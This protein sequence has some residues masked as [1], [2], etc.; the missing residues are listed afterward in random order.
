M[1][2]SA[3]SPAAST[4]QA[5]GGPTLL[6]RVKVLASHE[7]DAGKEND[8]VEEILIPKVRRLTW[9]RRF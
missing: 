5:F 3:P 6:P 2:S 4:L 8:M 7:E 9:W 1:S